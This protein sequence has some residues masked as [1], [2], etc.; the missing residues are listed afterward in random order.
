MSNTNHAQVRASSKTSISNWSFSDSSTNIY[1]IQQSKFLADKAE[2]KLGLSMGVYRTEN[3]EPYVFEVVREA[4]RRIEKAKG[5]KEY[6]PTVG[7]PEFRTLAAKLLFGDNSPVI[8]QGK[9]ASVQTIGGTCAIS[10]GAAFLR[11]MLSDEVEVYISNPAWNIYQPLL[12]QAGMRVQKYRYFNAKNLC[13]DFEGMCTDIESA[14][15]GSIIILQGCAHNPTGCDLN[16]EQWNRLCEICKA[17]QH[18]PFFD[19]A[20]QGFATGSLDDDAYAPRLF[21]ENGME[22]LVAQSFSKNFGL[23]GERVGALHLVLHDDKIV[24]NLLNE[25]QSL[26]TLFYGAPT[27]HGAQIVIEVLKDREL[28]NQWIEEL[29]QV[30]GRVVHVRQCLYNHLVEEMPE[31]N[32]ISVLSQVGMFLFIGLTPGQVKYL[33][34]KHHIYLLPDGRISLA[35]LASSKTKYLASAIVDSYR[36]QLVYKNG[37]H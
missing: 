27:I 24:D 21:A 7:D 26:I 34:E 30:S 14:H 3:D 11:K 28:C 31:M 20:Y 18:L 32:W 17:K 12:K 2:E 9:V 5:F 19:V 1:R 33:Q 13:L 10:I 6:P 23:Y 29:K 8:K 25:L 15:S 35:T 36:E 16:K 37:V 4:E 22:F